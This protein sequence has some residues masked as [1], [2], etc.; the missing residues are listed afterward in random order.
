MPTNLVFALSDIA[1]KS[2]SVHVCLLEAEGKGFLFE[3]VCKKPL[4]S[5]QVTRYH[6]ETGR[7]V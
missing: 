2:I 5:V 1:V 7:R 3:V 4:F 6:P